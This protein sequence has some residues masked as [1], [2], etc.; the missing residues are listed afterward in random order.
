[1]RTL[2]LALLAGLIVPHAV[3]AAQQCSQI[4]DAT[5]RLACYDNE[6]AQKEEKGSSPEEKTT[7]FV[8]TAKVRVSDLL[9][10]PES[11]RFTKLYTLTNRATN[12]QTL[13]GFV[14][15][16]NKV[17]GYNGPQ[18]FVS[19]EEKNETIVYGLVRGF[20]AYAAITRIKMLCDRNNPETLAND[21]EQ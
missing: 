21:I 3:F 6:R 11:A 8:K 20:E 4:E 1:M 2:Q 9:T 5:R 13:C 16:K 12:K 15:W 18:Y 17:G 14:N 10:D 19:S 7:T